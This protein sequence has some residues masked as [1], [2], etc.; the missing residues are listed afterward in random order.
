[1]SGHFPLLALQHKKDQRGR[2][3][4]A[5]ERASFFSRN[6]AWCFTTAAACWDYSYRRYWAGFIAFIRMIMY[7]TL[8]SQWI[9]AKSF[10]LFKHFFSFFS[11]A[12]TW[13]SFSYLSAKEEDEEIW[14]NVDVIFC[15]P[16]PMPIAMLGK[17]ERKEEEEEKGEE[18]EEGWKVSLKCEWAVKHH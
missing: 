9:E 16:L 11:I 18:E 15:S 14:A 8:L 7:Y 3:E 13:P 4:R 12:H 6:D 2:E 10:N 17:K 5:S 1:M